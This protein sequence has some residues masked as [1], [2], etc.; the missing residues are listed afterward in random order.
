[1]RVHKL[2]LIQSL[3]YW[4]RAMENEGEDR[5]METER[6]VDNTLK[7]EKNTFHY[8]NLINL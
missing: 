6:M 4:L 1:M 7:A 3:E 8:F 2:P 5:E